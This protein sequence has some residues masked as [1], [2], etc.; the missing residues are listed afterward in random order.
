MASIV[1]RAS[2][3]A[4][5][6]A[7]RN[8]GRERRRIANA[9]T[10]RPRCRSI[11]ACR[12][13][14]SNATLPPSSWR[15]RLRRA[16]RD[17]RDERVPEV[18]S[19]EAEPAVVVA[20]V[21]EGGQGRRVLRDGVRRLIAVEP[22]AG[23][24]EIHDRS[25]VADQPQRLGEAQ[26]KGAE[27]HEDDG[28]GRLGAQRERVTPHDDVQRRDLGDR[29]H[30]T[31]ARPAAR[32]GRN[33]EPGGAHP[34]AADHRELGVA[35]QRAD[36]AGER[37]GAHVARRL[38]RGHEDAHRPVSYGVAA[39][40]ASCGSSAS[41]RSSCGSRPGSPGADPGGSSTTTPGAMPLRS[42]S[43]PAAVR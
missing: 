22:R 19:L 37:R 42:M 11:S 12:L 9:S 25:T 24:E 7:P 1:A 40:A 10:S 14:G 16:R 39:G 5:P 23:R 38:A 27:V 15:R 28:I 31:H 17:Q 18:R 35:A 8:A 29:F 33:V 6:I 43:L 21:L 32:V 3:C 34:F 4:A 20:L 26:V 13:P 2:A 30:R 36:R 41:A